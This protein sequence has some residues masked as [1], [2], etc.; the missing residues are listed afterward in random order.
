MDGER[1]DVALDGRARRRGSEE[2]NGEGHGGR[3]LLRPAVRSRASDR[4]LPVHISPE[5]RGPSMA[6]VRKKRSRRAAASDVPFKPTSP[7]PP[8]HQA[9]PG[10]ES[11]MHPRPLF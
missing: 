10:I 5:K 2:S 4:I 1:G 3:K 6:S 11:K 7:F 9:K 8:Q